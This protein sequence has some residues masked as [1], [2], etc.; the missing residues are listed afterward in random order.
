MN[1]IHTSSAAVVAVFCL[2]ASAPANSQEFFESAYARPAEMVD[3]LHVGR[4]IE[5]AG[6]FAP[7]RAAAA[8]NCHAGSACGRRLVA[9]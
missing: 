1:K 4:R 3:G 5:G 8:Q 7:A 2:T 9:H 6:I